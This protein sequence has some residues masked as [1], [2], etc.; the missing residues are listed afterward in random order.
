MQTTISA[1]FGDELLG[2]VKFSKPKK[3]KATKDLYTQR[4]WNERTQ[5]GYLAV[6]KEQE[7]GKAIRMFQISPLYD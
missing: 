4:I 1:A 2:D 7:L 5:T 3:L 6:L